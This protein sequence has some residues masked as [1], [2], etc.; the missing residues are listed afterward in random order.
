MAP[1]VVEHLDAIEDSSPG[2]FAF[3]ANSPPN[4][5]TLEQL[6]EA[7]GDGIVVSVS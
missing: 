3:D 1:W 6:E 4:A 2:F 7:F 5:L